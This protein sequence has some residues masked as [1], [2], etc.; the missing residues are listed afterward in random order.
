M[1]G[2]DISDLYCICQKPYIEGQFMIECGKCNEWFHGSCVGIEEYHAQDIDIYHCP[3][4]QPVHGPLVLKKR[5]NVSRHNYKDIH[6]GIKQISAGSV[7]FVRQLKAR[8]FFNAEDIVLQLEDGSN[9]TADYF[10]EHGFNTPVL[11]HEKTGLDL[12]VPPSNFTVYDVEQRIGSLHEVH[13]IDVAKQEDLRMKMREWTEYYNSP[14][15]GKVLNVISLEFSNTSLS[16]LVACPK[17]VRN[18]SWAEHAWPKKSVEDSPHAKPIVEKYCLMS[19]KDCY[20]DF[21]VDFGGTSVWYHIIRGEK[22]FYFVEPTAENLNK[23]KQ[24]VSSSDQGQVFFGE[25]VSKCYRLHVKQGNTLLIPSGWIHAVLTPK[26]SLVFGGNFLH[27]FDIGLQQKIYTLEKELKTPLKFLFPNYETTNWYAARSI[28][29]KMKEI[30]GL[31]VRIPNFLQDGVTALIAALKVWTSRKD[32]YVK[33]HKLQVPIEINAH[34][35]IKSLENELKH[36]MKLKPE[37]VFPVGRLSSPALLSAN[38]AKT[39]LKLKLARPSESESSSMSSPERNIHDRLTR[40]KERLQRK[41]RKIK[42]EL[43]SQGRLPSLKLNLTSEGIRR[44]RYK[45]DDDDEDERDDNEDDKK[46]RKIK[47]LVSL[48]S[49]DEELSSS[50]EPDSSIK[51]KLSLSK[52]RADNLSSGSSPD[53]LGQFDDPFSNKRTQPVAHRL[54]KHIDIKAEI[55]ATKKDLFQPDEKSVK[56]KG[57]YFTPLQRDEDCTV[58]PITFNPNKNFPRKPKVDGDDDIKEED[59]GYV[60]DHLPKPKSNSVKKRTHSETDSDYDPSD[61]SYYQDANYVYPRIDVTSD[62]M[63]DDFSWKPGQRKKPKSSG[64]RGRKHSRLNSR[65]LSKDECDD[66]F[67]APDKA[68]MKNN[69]KKVPPAS[70]PGKA[71][72]TVAAGEKKVFKAKKGTAKQR[73]GKLLKLDKTGSRYVR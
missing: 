51:L 68:E 57:L 22:V 41:E 49:S 40:K 64:D 10:Q 39:V 15:R 44:A 11:I 3:K 48:N 16:E 24:W 53:V 50:N 59:G 65:S 12:T 28:L 32:E 55:E 14:V 35:L 62:L 72:S 56:T 18:I 13:V 54:E 43:F 37:K 60:I 73:L 71:E 2:E 30:H 4:C 5:R 21:H 58:K 19:V 26:D 7:M 69:L 46:I 34:K 8:K 38:V 42:E 9:V 20:T 6:E 67:F 25:K 23:F 1:G 33:Y 31:G 17:F 63:I 45:F 47:K 36:D 61:D 27:S 29:K 70:Q 52:N 66:P